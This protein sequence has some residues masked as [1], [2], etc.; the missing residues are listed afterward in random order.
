MSEEAV[1]IIRNWL[2]IDT[3]LKQLNKQIKEKRLIKKNLT[4]DLVNLMK[5]KEI[6]CFE[7]QEGKLLYTKN[8][9][10]K[11]I[12]KKHLISS[13]NTFFENKDFQVQDLCDYILNTRAITVK[14]Y[15]KRK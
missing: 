3:E 10:K 8:R 1:K 14:E 4:M 15:I 5:T 11:P 9:I 7:L 13:L 2:T 12:S 6:D